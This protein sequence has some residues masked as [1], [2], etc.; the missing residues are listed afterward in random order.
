MLD[1]NSILVFSENPKEL[2]EF[3]KKVF[4]KDPD[5]K[6]YGYFGFLAGKGFLTI[7]PHGKVKGESK[8]PE[9]IKKLN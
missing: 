3:Y 9:R 6:D 1:L 7:G 2:S 5:W 8:N 4:Q